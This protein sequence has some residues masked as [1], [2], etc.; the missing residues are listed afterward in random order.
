MNKHQIKMETH[1][2]TYKALMLLA[3]SLAL[4]LSAPAFAKDG[5]HRAAHH[6]KV[7][8][9]KSAHKEKVEAAK[10]AHQE[11]VEE[12][13]ENRQGKSRSSKRGSSRKMLKSARKIVKKR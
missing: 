10:E 9:A 4:T 6:G 12:R 2:M 3:S 5:E 7:E 1:T 8:A 11:R 13:K